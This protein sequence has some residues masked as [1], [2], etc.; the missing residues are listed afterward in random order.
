MYRRLRRAARGN[1]G[2]RRYIDRWFG[3]SVALGAIIVSLAM[4]ITGNEDFARWLV[5][6]QP[7]LA[8]LV[9]L[10]AILGWHRN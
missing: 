1:V 4:A 6:M 10:G 9:L 2:F 8:A 7:L 3:A 5:A